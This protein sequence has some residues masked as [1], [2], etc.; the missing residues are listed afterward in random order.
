[1]RIYIKKS[2]IK[3][4]YKNVEKFLNYEK[5]IGIT[6]FRHLK[7]FETFAKNHKYKLRKLIKSYLKNNIICG[8][9]AAAKG[10]TLLNYSNLNSK[11]IKFIFDENKLKQNKFFPGTDIKIISPKKIFKINPEYI[12]IL[13]WN[14]QKEIIKKIKR[15]SPKVKFIIPYPDVRILK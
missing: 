3:K 6:N 14:I 13:A 5:K 8:Y 1:M 11:D 7:K 9:G 4:S 10:N 2:K 15:I 12:L